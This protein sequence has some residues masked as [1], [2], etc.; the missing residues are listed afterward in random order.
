MKIET[1]KKDII[2]N[3]IGVFMSF[4]YGLV[5]LPFSVWFL[6]GDSL[7]LWYVF[8]SIGAIAVLMDFGFSPTFGRNINY[9]WSGAR[10]L[11]KEGAVFAQDSSE[12]DF[13]LVKKVLNTC[14]IIYGIISSVALL[15][16]LT[17]G[18]FY[19]LY[20]TEYENTK[21]YLT[22]WFIYAAAIFMNLYFGYYSSFLRGVG[23]VADNNK[24]VVFGRIVQ[25]LLTI[26]LL[27]LGFGIIGCCIAYMSHG[28]IFRLI[29]KNKF[30][31][32]KGIGESLKNVKQKIEKSEIKEMFLT[33]WYNAWRDGLVSLS[34]YLMTQASTI[35]CSM[36]LSLSQTGVYS[37][38]LQVASV[39]V[40]VASAFFTTSIPSMQ[41][42]YVTKDNEK[43]RKTFSLSVV[44]YLFVSIAGIAGFVIVG[45]PLL[46]FLKPDEIITVPLALGVSAS[47][48]I[49]HFRKCYTSYFSCTNRLPYVRSLLVS[50]VFSVVIAI[51]LMGV[52]DLGTVG[53][54]SSQ[55]ISQLVYN[56]WAW[57]IKVHR[58]LELPFFKMPEIAFK[59][60]KQKIKSR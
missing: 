34:S 47:Q 27:F 7:G 30:Y 12:P 21:V 52:F 26:V 15:L 56:V 43:M 29:A 20:V 11:Q 55:I 41:S 59:T 18:S 3:Y 51:V 35:I 37:L 44:I 48:F 28:I 49:I 5:M 23:A 42:A 6:D 32:Y 38:A 16:L 22:A 17:A 25:I 13:Y 24:A 10:K 4:G 1:S 40:T 46:K 60:V 50:S 36:F 33:I 9:C 45:I 19:V 2:W 39:I 8:Q 14:K 31:K 54:I 57:P 58:E 53:L